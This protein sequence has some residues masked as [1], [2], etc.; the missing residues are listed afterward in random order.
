[1]AGRPSQVF[2]YHNMEVGEEYSRDEALPLA[3]VPPPSNSREITGITRFKNCVVLFVTLDKDSKAEAYRYNNE[4]LIDG[5]FFQ[6][7]SQNTNTPST[8]HMQ[9]IFAKEPVVLF[10]RPKANHKGKTSRFTYVGRLTYLQYSYD[11]SEPNKPVW[12]MY[13]VDDHQLSPSPSLKALYDWVPGANV[14]VEETAFD[15]SASK[16]I[17]TAPPK[18]RN[19]NNTKGGNSTDS[20]RG[21]K[22]EVDWAARDEANRNLGLAG[23]ELVITHEKEAL[24]RQGKHKLAAKIKHVALEDPKAGYDVL[25][26]DADGNEKYIEVK[27]TKGSASNAF[28]ISR[29]EVEVSEAKGDNYWI[30]RVHSYIKKT[31]TW[32]VYKLQGPVSD[33]FELTPESF[34]AKTKSE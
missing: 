7:E 32:K 4:F 22:G 10:A 13:N 12:V 27:T 26:F 16:L 25:S 34:K 29:N 1:M 9:M 8:P 15:T 31:D 28:Y 2:N 5:K 24:E 20:Q 14:A 3:N 33:S 18:R 19:S 17:E 21:Q 23:E 6:W 30:Y 11:A